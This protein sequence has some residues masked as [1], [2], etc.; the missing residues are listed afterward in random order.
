M[1]KVPSKHK[2]MITQE[3]K[4]FMPLIHN[5]QAKGKSSS[6][7]D[8]RILLNDILS[9]VLG[10]DKYNE[11]K[12][13]MR[14][15]NSRYDYVVKLMEG[16]NSKKKDK[17][18]FVIEAKAAHIE[19]NQH[20]IDQTMSYC[21]TKGMDFFMLT[22]AVKWRLYMVK[23]SKKEPTANLIHEVDFGT[24]NSPESLAEE[25]YLFSKASYL[26]NDW[27]SVSEQVKATKVEDVVAVILS[28]KVIKLVTK[29]LSTLSGLKISEDMVKEI[30]ENQIVKSSVDTVNKKLLKK[31]NEKPAKKSKAPK[32]SDT[33]K[34]NSSDECDSTEGEGATILQL[35]VTNTSE[36]TVAKDQDNPAGSSTGEEKKA[37]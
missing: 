2:K 3:L 6:E 4:R 20:H 23:R 10:Y 28:D 1:Y 24:N 31:I 29:E 5:L 11:L 19:L 21:L 27:K 9:Y 18:D 36:S 12:T 32:S 37:A 30:I 7:D 22:N 34:S 17:F 8:A 15:K 33:S 16:P 26:N 13:E 14:E 35:P 25:F